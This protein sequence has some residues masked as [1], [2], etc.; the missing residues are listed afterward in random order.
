VRCRYCHEEDNAKREMDTKPQKLMARR[1]IEMTMALNKNSFGG[2]AAV[3]CNSCHRGSPRPMA[4][5]PAGEKGPPEWSSADELTKP[6]EGGEVPAMDQILDRYDGA[7]GGAGAAQKVSTLAIKATVADISGKTTAVDIIAKAPGASVVTIHNREADAIAAVNG[8]SG[9]V[10]AERGPRDM[11][12]NELEAARLED[13]TYVTGRIKQ[14]FNDLRVAPRSEKIDGRE[15]YVISGRSLGSTAVRLYFDKQSGML[16][17][18]V[19]N[20]QTVF[21]PYYTQVDYADFRDAG[22]LKIPY[23]WKVSRVRGE[24]SDYQVNDAKVNIPIDETRFGKPAAGK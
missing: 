22:G 23:R 3:T 11:R 5:P 12:P 8:N 15:A 7:I 1:M 20:T 2:R 10:T 17:R 13:P 14:V 19:Y 16:S 9:W 6:A 4:I 24:L 18:L 21:G